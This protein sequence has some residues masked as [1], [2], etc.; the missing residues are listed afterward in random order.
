MIKLLNKIFCWNNIR[1]ILVFICVYWIVASIT[2]GFRHP[3][4]TDTQ[5]I[6]H[7]LDIIKWK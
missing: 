7:F 4:M 3:E 5:R 1:Y 6:L 2:Y